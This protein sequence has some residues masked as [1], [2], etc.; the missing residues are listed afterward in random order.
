MFE[1]YQ[2]L[3]SSAVLGLLILGSSLILYSK[4]N[5]FE[6]CKKEYD[7]FGGWTTSQACTNVDH[8]YDK[9]P[10]S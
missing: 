7:K 4:P 3:I 8:R 2:I 1:K 5:E 9:P 10:F 6:S